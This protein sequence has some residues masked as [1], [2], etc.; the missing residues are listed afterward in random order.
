[1]RAFWPLP[2]F[3][4]AL[5]SRNK[6]LSFVALSLS[7]VVSRFILRSH[8][9]REGSD[10]RQVPSARR[11]RRDELRR[12]TF[13]GASAVCGDRE[14]KTTFR[15]VHCRRSRRRGRSFRGR[16][17][18]LRS[19]RRLCVQSGKGAERAKFGFF[20]RRPSAFC[21][22]ILPIFASLSL[23]FSLSL[24]LSFSLSLSLPLYPHTIITARR[25]LTGV[26]G[27]LLRRRG[28]SGSW[29]GRRKDGSDQCID[30]SCYHSR[31]G[32]VGRG[33]SSNSSSSNSTATAAAARVPSS[34]HGGSDGADS[35]SSR[36]R[37]GKRRRRCCRTWGSRL[38]G[39]SAAAATAARWPPRRPPSSAP[40]ASAASAL[41]AARPGRRIGGRW[42][43]PLRWGRIRSLCG[44]GQR[45]GP[46]PREDR[47]EAADFDGRRC[48]EHPRCCEQ[49]CYE[50]P[51]C[52]GR[53]CCSSRRRCRCPPR[54]RRYSKR[55]AHSSHRYLGPR[56]HSWCRNP[57]RGRADDDGD[58]DGGRRDGG[59][60]GGRDRGGGGGEG[61][62]ASPAAALG[63]GD[64]PSG[65]SSAPRDR[66]H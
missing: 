32:G 59:G 22:E 45:P 4:V 1:V 48:C 7:R 29:W 58:G 28:R 44:R 63:A 24:S 61:G 34:L 37:E 18:A 21:S 39:P 47:L 19:G 12:T 60:R 13:G 2:F 64:E 31:G 3:S 57:G 38:R 14:L 50:R 33:S 65:P 56:G 66:D 5:F 55:G 15:N 26:D 27:Y 16:R 17:R 6:A 46:R 62:R 35:A 52:R 54:R 25:P 40:S 10:S 42:P 43:F 36:R 51:R 41:F 53:S 20:W 9:S 49:P 23:Y 8:P 11:F 30:W